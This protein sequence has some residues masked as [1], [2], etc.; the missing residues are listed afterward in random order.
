M[1]DTLVDSGCLLDVVMS[2]AR[3]LAWSAEQLTIAADSGN[4]VI[5]PII[6]AEVA[7]GYRDRDELE[8]A[9][10][11]RSLLRADLPWEAAFPAS[12]AFVAYRRR[13]GTRHSP[14]PDFYIGAHAEIRGLTLL[15][16]D[17]NRYRTYFPTVQII[18]PDTNP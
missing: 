3:W 6:Y 4:V 10:A 12:R 1:T 17:P 15:T 9:L 8:A 14:L 13:G 2:D 7:A 11:H 18:A 16:R 5:N